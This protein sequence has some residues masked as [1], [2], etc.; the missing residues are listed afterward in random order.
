MS[1]FKSIILSIV[2]SIL[3]LACEA[4]YYPKPNGFN[5]I[6]LPDH[7]YK[8]LPDSFP[9]SFEYSTH[10]KILPDSSYIRERYWF[11]LFYPKFVAEVHITY[12]SLNNNR[13][14][15]RANIDDAY[16]L[17]T[18]HQIKASSIQETILMTPTGKKVSIAELKGD[19][20]SQFQFYTTDST[21]HFLRGALYFRTATENDSLAPVIEYVKKDIIHSLN[22][23]EWD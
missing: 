11:A 1:L 20:P 5:R 10:A 2:V 23:L 9:Y 19:V 7:E 22:T 3:F 15:L 8:A 14:S 4:D 21:E 16:K 6:D 13:D 12:K 18:K 17:T